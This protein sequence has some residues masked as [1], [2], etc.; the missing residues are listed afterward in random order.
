[1]KL[2]ILDLIQNINVPDDATAWHKSTDFF[3]QYGFHIT[4]FGMIDKQSHAFMGF[5]SNMR[6]EWM[7]HYMSSN[8]AADDPFC[9]YILGNYDSITCSRSGESELVIAKGSTGAKMINEAE[10]EGFESSLCIPINNYH[11]TKIT[12]FN[13]ISEMLDDDFKKVIGEHKDEILLG[14][15]LI[16]NRIS[17]VPV[18]SEQKMQWT[19]N[20]KCGVLMSAREIEVLYLLSEGHRNDRIAEKLNIAS[21]TVNFHLK[22]IRLKLGCQTREQ[23]VAMAFKK[24][25]LR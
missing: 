7:E 18:C 21:V 13:L 9:D 8:Y 11:D 6:D 16:N 14:A 15:A 1:M 10:S 19:P 25:F 2:E 24:G 4:N 3:A 12:G 23:A 5:H 17:E 22:E 20:P